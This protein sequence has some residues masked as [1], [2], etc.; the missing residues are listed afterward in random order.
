MKT[1][2]LITYH[3]VSANL[4]EKKVCMEFEKERVLSANCSLKHVPTSEI[5]LNL[6]R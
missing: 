2:E 6:E 4:V 3:R 5:Y 1:T